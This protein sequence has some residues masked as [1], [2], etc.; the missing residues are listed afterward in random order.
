MRFLDHLN[1][2]DADW[3]KA[4]LPSEQPAAQK[5]GK[6]TEAVTIK[7][8]RFKFVEP[9]QGYEVIDKA[10]TAIAHDGD[11]P[12]VT[13]YDDCVLVMPTHRLFV[14]RSAVRLGH[15]TDPPPR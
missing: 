12:V 14:G 4:Q 7:T 1:V 15:Y 13:P 10:G 5:I 3:A 11:E 6:V 9:Y 2:V 8:E